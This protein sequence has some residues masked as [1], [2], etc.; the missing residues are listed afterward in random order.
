ME[1]GS[2]KD[3]L[4]RVE[5]KMNEVDP[6]SEEFETLRKRS[7]EIRKTINEE[8]KRRANES[9]EKAKTA[10][11]LEI[12]RLELTERVKDRWVK[13]G[14]GFGLG[15]LTLCSIFADETRVAC[16]TALDVMDRGRRMLL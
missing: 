16:R 12:K 14:L 9:N 13:V 6:L 3:Q 1:L 5:S 15:I 11:E 2:I 4:D 8:E 10:G 7:E